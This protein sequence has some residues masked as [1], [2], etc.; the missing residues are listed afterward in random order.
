MHY[1]FGKDANGTEGLPFL[2]QEERAELRIAFFVESSVAQDG[3]FGCA[4]GGQF[5]KEML[6]LLAILH[7]LG[8]GKKRILAMVLGEM[9]FVEPADEGDGEFPLASLIDV[10]HIDNIA[11]AVGDAELFDR[12]RGFYVGPEFR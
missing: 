6:F 8:I 1:G 12:Y 5:E 7:T 9:A 2:F 10:E 11:T 3:F 4:G